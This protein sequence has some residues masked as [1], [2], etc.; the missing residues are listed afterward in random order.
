M[1]IY[2]DITIFKFKYNDKILT[3]LS[4]IFSNVFLG[5]FDKKQLLF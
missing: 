3:L 2:R 5:K 1:G 4:S